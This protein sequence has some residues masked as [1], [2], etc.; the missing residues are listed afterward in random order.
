MF[1][2]MS[3]R[4]RRKRRLDSPVPELID[5]SDSG[6]D[7]DLCGGEVRARSDATSFSTIILRDWCWGKVFAT[8]VHRYC[9]AAFRD[10]LTSSQDVNDIAA[11]GGWGANPEKLHAQLTKKFLSDVIFPPAEVFKVHCLDPRTMK[12][13]QHNCH[14]MMPHDIFAALFTSQPIEFEE[15]FGLERMPEFWRGASRSEFV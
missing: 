7:S 3:G 11:M 2:A 12:V 1:A 9:L 5:S 6:S 8:D 10:G 14:A 4:G 15:Y 13:I